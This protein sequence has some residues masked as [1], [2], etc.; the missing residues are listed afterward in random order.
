MPRMLKNCSNFSDLRDLAKRRLPSPIFNY[1]DGAADDDTLE[2]S[3]G[4]ST[5]SN[6]ASLVNIEIIKANASGGTINLAGQTEG[7][8]ITGNTAVDII[9]GGDGQSQ[10]VRRWTNPIQQ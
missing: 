2:L 8:T 1:I 7:F 4:T 5:F 3:T 9:T 10:L 6:N